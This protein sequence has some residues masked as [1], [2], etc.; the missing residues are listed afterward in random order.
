VFADLH[1]VGGGRIGLV[2]GRGLDPLQAPEIMIHVNAGE[3]RARELVEERQPGRQP[4]RH[5][6][7]VNFAEERVAV[8]V[9]RQ[10]A[11]AVAIGIEQAVCIGRG[12]E[13]EQLA[14]QGHRAAQ[15]RFKIGLGDRLGRMTDHAQ[16]NL[17][18]RVEETTAG[19]APFLV[20][21]IDEVTRT[22]VRGHL[23]QQPRE[24][25]GLEG[26]ILE[27]RPGP[28]PGR[29]IR[30]LHGH[31]RSPSLVTASGRLQATRS[32]IAGGGVGRFGAR[33]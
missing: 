14:P 7:A 28:R 16:R 9:D 10:P 18:A 12:I 4:L 19:K 6:Q 25:R 30:R 5:P 11:Q 33:R 3:L 17:G 2:E 26:E 31:P 20:V 22:R 24:D 32:T 29:A 23:A 1:P 15:R 27:L 13:L 21:D 8:A